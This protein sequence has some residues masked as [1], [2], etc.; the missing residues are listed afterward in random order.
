MPWALAFVDGAP[1]GET[2]I[3]NMQVP[4]GPHEILLR[5]PQLGERR[6]SVTV[7]SRETAKVGVDLERSDR[8]RC[9]RYRLS[10]WSR[11]LEDEQAGPHSIGC[12]RQPA[13]IDVDIVDLNGDRLLLVDRM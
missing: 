2:P 12:V 9:D 8:A 13:M 10:A 7:T 5:H 6:A 1:A 3:A 4:I 11:V